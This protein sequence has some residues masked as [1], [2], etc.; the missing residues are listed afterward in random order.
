[1]SMCLVKQNDGTW[2]E[3]INVFLLNVYKRF[4]LARI[5]SY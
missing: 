3:K 1:M 4:I 5:T 2:V